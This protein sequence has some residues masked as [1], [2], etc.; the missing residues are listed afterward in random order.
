ML[1]KNTIITTFSVF[2]VSI[3]I[4]FLYLTNKAD[5]IAEQ[6]QM[7]TSY[8]SLMFINEKLMLQNEG[9]RNG[10]SLRVK[11]LY[12]NYYD[13]YDDNNFR[14]YALY[15]SPKKKYSLRQ[16]ARKFNIDNPQ[17]AWS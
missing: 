11:V 12:N 5:W 4:V 10:D 14:M 9:L 1:D 17:S 15:K 3:F 6:K 2:V 13:A 8:D 16:L 7:Q